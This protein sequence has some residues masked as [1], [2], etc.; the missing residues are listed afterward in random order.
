MMVLRLTQ[1]ALYKKFGIRKQYHKIYL[2]KLMLILLFYR[3]IDILI[4]L[5]VKQN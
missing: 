3:S 2:L 5:K 1:M 4:L